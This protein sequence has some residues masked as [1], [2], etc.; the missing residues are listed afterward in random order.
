MSKN[1]SRLALAVLVATA[2]NR[3]APTPT[4]DDDASQHG[5]PTHPD[6]A[7]ASLATGVNDAMR[8]ADTSGVATVDSAAAGSGGGALP[9]H[10]GTS[11]T[12]G[13]R[14]GDGGTGIR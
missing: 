14:H 12:G 2:C 1:I 8:A 9:P 11:A 3:S 13:T 7:T 10:G 5:G 6:T 4:E